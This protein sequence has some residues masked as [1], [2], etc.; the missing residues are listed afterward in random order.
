M[1]PTGL[2]DGGEDR[3]REGGEGREGEKGVDEDVENMEMMR[4]E[5]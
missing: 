3:R 4:G 2:S 5:Q 1:C